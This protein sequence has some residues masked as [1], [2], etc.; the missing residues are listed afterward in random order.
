[1]RFL[2]FST[3]DGPGGAGRAASRLHAALQKAGN[4]SSMLVRSRAADKVRPALGGRPRDA[5]DRGVRVVPT[6]SL[7]AQFRRLQRHV[8]AVGV[9]R[10]KFTFNF[11]LS[12]GIH[13]QRVLRSV[14]PPPDA[15]CLHWVAEFLTSKAIRQIHHH[16][17]CPLLWTVM[18][19]EP[20]TGGCHYSFG[21]QGY[22]RQ[23]GHCPL[24]DRPSIGDWSRQVFLR[25]Q[26]FLADLPITF[27]AP[28][29]WVEERVR[30]SALFGRHRVQRIA[31]PIDTTVFR[32][33][34]RQEARRLLGIPLNLRVVFF[35]S[36]YLHE[37]RKGGAFLIEALR[38]LKQALDH[39]SPS[40]PRFRIG[41]GGERP[42]LE[43]ADVLLLVAGQSGDDLKRQLPFAI[44]DLGYLTDERRLAAAYRAADVF[45]CPSVE[46]AG[47]MM[48]PEAMLSGAPVVAF[49]TG[50]AP[51]LV[52][53]GTTGFLARLGDA[54]HLALG[55]LQVLALSDRGTMGATAAES[56]RRL[57]E[58]SI[59]AKQ[60]ASLVM[61]LTESHREAAA[62]NRAA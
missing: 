25:K 5:D 27:V 48:I 26:R 62:R 45:V 61:G 22:Q 12:R 59:V 17:H 56:A 19:Q 29:S 23:C 2:H 28:T 37:P 20:I 54:A 58:P 47:P 51:D 40:E 38:R 4:D 53:T 10:S 34:D 42:S 35:G 9:P 13:W 32:P 31:L 15:V 60:Y 8:P 11:D 6:S 14:A 44:H 43:A 50:G 36:S 33:G 3:S 1:M 24:L 52:V 41:H 55:L 30:K 46:D 57:H 21:C 49:N 16:F 7:V 39:A 18:D